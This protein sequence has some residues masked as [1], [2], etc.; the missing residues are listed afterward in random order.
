MPGRPLRALPAFAHQPWQMSYG[1]R[2][3]LEGMLQM[4]K[5]R[6]AIEIGRAEGG[7]LNRIAA[8]S[9]QVISFD[10]VEPWPEVAE[11][12]NVTAL[13]GDS[14]ALLP[15]ELDRLAAAGETVDFVLVDGD[16]SAEGVRQ[17]IE[18]LLEAEA[19]AHTV[20]LIHDTLNQDVRRGV[21]AVDL[22]AH[23]KVSWVELDFV[24]G[25]VA[26]LPERFGECWGGIGLVIADDSGE[27]RSG[28]P[29]HNE[30]LFE[31][32]KLVWPVAEWLRGEGAAAAERLSEVTLVSDEELR[33]AQQQVIA[34]EA[35]LDRHR[36]WLQDMKT[37]ASWRLT[38]PL[39][40]AKRRLRSR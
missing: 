14:H 32:P 3:V 4:V 8:H 26:R 13:S 38:V 34:L 7:S 36:G 31:Q 24:P 40:K 22:E 28:G 5:P 15:K 6:I 9:G 1:E 23:Q 20:I 17:D 33:S 21:E 12:A 37:S 29:L 35:E 27:F 16:H 2:A 10:L 19:I 18:Q 30:L 25:Y 11:L 39:R